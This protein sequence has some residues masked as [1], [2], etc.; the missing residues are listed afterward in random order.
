M[1][2]EINQDEFE[3]I[4]ISLSNMVVRST[5]TIAGKCRELENKLINSAPDNWKNEMIE[6]F[7]K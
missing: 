4:A 1:L 7:D 5:G 2:L 3:I 6:G